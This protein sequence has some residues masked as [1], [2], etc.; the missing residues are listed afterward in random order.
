[1]PHASP[2]S[3]VANY[4]RAV[5]RGATLAIW[6]A[7]ALSGGA[8][9]SYEICWSR[10][11]VVPLGN[12][13]DAAAIVLAGFMLGIAVGA[14]VGGAWS[15]RAARPLRDYAALEVA[16]G[17][18]ALVAPALLDSLSTSSMVGLRYL[19][20]VA[21]ITLPGLAMGASLPLLVRALTSD[22]EPLRLH[23]S[24]AYGANTAG[25][26]LGAFV[27]GF[28]GLATV[29]VM[30]CSAY[31]AAASVVAALLAV[32]V[33]GDSRQPQPDASADASR[34][35]LRRLA[36]AAAF[37]SGFAMLASELLWARVLTFVFG[38]DTYA[39]ASL[40]ALVLLGLGIG[41]F[42]Q[43]LLARFDQGKLLAALLA[44]SALALLSSFW[45]SASL[46]VEHGRDPFDLQGSGS[47]ATS[48][49]LELLRELSYTPLLVLLPSLVAGAS[50]PTACTLYAGRGTDSGR[51]VGIIGLVNGVGSA[52]GAVVGAFGLVGAFGIQRSFGVLALACGAASAWALFQ[53]A[54]HRDA[55]RAV[56]AS[57]PFVAI[58]ALAMTMPRNLPRQ[59]LLA[60][61]GARHNSLLFYREGRTATVSVIE[62]SV[63]DERQLLINAV[64]E[65]T[66]RLVHDQSFKV[67]GHLAPLLHPKPEAGLMIC[68][69]AGIAAGAAV[70]HPLR[71]LDV[72][73]LSPLVAHAA[74]HFAPENN[75]VLDHPSFHLHIADGRQFLLNSDGR[76]DVAIVDS[77]HPKAVDSWILYTEEFYQLLRQHL[78]DGGIALQWLPLHGLSEREFKIIV[79]T[80]QSVFPDMTLWANAGVETYG[81]V[82]YAKLLGTRNGPLVIDH[83]RLTQRLNDP[84]V[85]RDLA[86]YG[87]ASAA[88]L[89]DLFVAGPE[90]IAAW[91][92]GLP[93]QTDDHPLVPY[94]TDYSHGR[95]MEPRL[96]LTV[97]SS[98]APLL[99]NATADEVS[100][101]E[102]AHDTQGLVLAGLL[103]QAAERR[104]VGAKVRLY[105]EQRRTTEPYYL[106]L[107]E[108][109][110]DDPDQLFAFGTQL[111]N[112][113]HPGSARRLYQRVLSLR[114]H[115]FKTRLNVALLDLG[116][117]DV[118]SAVNSLAT[119]RAEMPASPIVLH[120]LGVAVLATQEPSVAAVHFEEA[121][122]LDPGSLP[123][124]LSLGR[125]YLQAKQLDRAEATVRAVVDRNRFVAAAH[126]LLGHIATARRDHRAAAEHHRRATELAPY[127]AASHQS[128]GLALQASDQPA[129]RAFRAVLAIEPHHADALDSL[130]RAHAQRGDFER[131]AD[132]HLQA[133][134]AD[135]H[136]SV[137]AH[138]LGLALRGQGRA[139]DA[140]G[141]FCL[142]LR[143]APNLKAAQQQLVELGKPTVCAELD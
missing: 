15:E 133:L 71:R 92:E 13:M 121:L 117:G 100:A 62:N 29:G 58:W 63:N 37:V 42:A 30:R 80:F 120:N 90:A 143:L 66:T 52:L 81:Q 44:S 61:V 102:Q 10:A 106:A 54:T 126:D 131:A 96:L 118:S 84:R 114:S 21:L 109:Y 82:A 94:T 112:L 98:V 23:I 27:T 31:A 17:A 86:S 47:F 95:R 130:G 7:A 105:R 1:M 49:W 9:L 103:D 28:W 45:F 57:L 141:A 75:G 134:D 3:L 40:L 116:A 135:P 125:A 24:I 101:I 43:R 113:G 50:F 5:R 68:L 70:A 91:T 53:L 22:G 97:R 104:P 12:S 79:R 139:N 11:L 77:T 26:A 78:A 46:V 34:F 99:A 6:V 48:V 142:A 127:S 20:A 111:G 72:V 59:M 140:V 35:K 108:I 41:G 132:L 129:D 128:L 39:F 88:E 93:T 19:A 16:L 87:V 115:D 73:D 64:N 119:L 122:A 38:H 8:A 110:A 14:R 51:S 55:R 69:G 89:L 124:R 76:Y 33:G 137:A 56:M 67:L 136:R 123:I 2:P 83:A 85:G 36:M 18:Y 65:V 107:A 74:R 32:L 138:N 60:S 4:A 25:A